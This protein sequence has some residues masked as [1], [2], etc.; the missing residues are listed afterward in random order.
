MGV[1][2]KLKNIFYD[3]EYIEEPEEARLTFKEKLIMYL[4]RN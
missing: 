4:K 3:E 1:F 2:T